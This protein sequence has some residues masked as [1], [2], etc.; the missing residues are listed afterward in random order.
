MDGKAVFQR[1]LGEPIAVVRVVV[2]GEENALAVVAAPD[3][4]QRLIGEK[5]AA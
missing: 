4:V 3:D 2:R 1:G 5:D